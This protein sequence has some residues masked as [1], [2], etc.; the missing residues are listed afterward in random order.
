MAVIATQDPVD[1][2]YRAIRKQFNSTKEYL[3]AKRALFVQPISSSFEV[4]ALIEHLAR[5]LPILAAWAATPGIAAFAARYEGVPTY[6]VVTEYQTTRNALIS[7][8]DNLTAAFPKNPSDF[9]L[10]EKFAADGTR[11]YRSFTSADMASAVAAI[12]AVLATFS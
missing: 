10:Y 6:D 1:I 7:L 4:V 11:T 9:L 5:V 2:A 12:D 8:R 3:E